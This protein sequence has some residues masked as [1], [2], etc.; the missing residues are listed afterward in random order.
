MTS[1]KQPHILNA[2]SNLLGICFV[3]ISGLKL[4]GSSEDTLADEIC[5]VAAILLL[6]SCVLS[7]ISLRTEHGSLFYEKIADYF[8]LTALFCLFIAV[9]IFGTGIL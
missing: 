9:M 2:S 7:Y 3:L 5:L 8:F 1:G 6:G 4:T